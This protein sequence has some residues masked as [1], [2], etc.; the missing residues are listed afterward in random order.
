[1]KQRWASRTA[2]A[3]L[4][5]AC[6]SSACGGD[7]TT[8]LADQGADDLLRVADPSFP[9]TAM[10]G[11]DPGCDQSLDCNPTAIDLLADIYALGQ[12]DYPSDEQ[13]VFSGSPG[14]LG[15]LL[16]AA[17]HWQG[18]SRFYP[19]AAG[20][21]LANLMIVTRSMDFDRAR[22][23]F[24]VYDWGSA[25]MLAKMD[26]RYDESHTQQPSHFRHSPDAD[27][28][29]SSCP[30][31]IGK[32]FVMGA[33]SKD[34]GGNYRSGK[35]PGPHAKIK[36]FDASPL[37]QSPAQKPRVV[38]EQIAVHE[39]SQPDEKF[40]AAATGII[41]LSS[42]HFLVASL[43]TEASEPSQSECLG[44]LLYI[45]ST[46]ELETSSWRYIDNV[47]F[48]S[49]NCVDCDFHPYN[50]LH[51]ASD[52]SGAIFGLLG[53]NSLPL[54]GYGTNYVSL[55]KLSIGRNSASGTVLA[56]S[57]ELKQP[58]ES[59]VD[60]AAA[61]GIFIDPTTKKLQIY[62]TEHYDDTCDCQLVTNSW[63]F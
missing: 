48:E 40:A 45:S 17:D 30:Q 31:V 28:D 4:I 6:C 16:A 8:P 38:G 52:D 44:I 11:S 9:L 29:H 2:C 63:S 19:A 53:Y 12:L 41:K 37:G 43:T 7:G 55:I 54:P 51:L 21:R 33:E 5:L 47:R 26:F 35:T 25:S 1:M 20:G 13:R 39:H 14:A 57:V 24:E 3:F 27:Y 59:K 10:L 32:Y 50:S 22:N 62:G 18:V 36:I 58:G 49:E 15:G 42:G 23:Q 60:F 61:M 46:T 56:N 34:G